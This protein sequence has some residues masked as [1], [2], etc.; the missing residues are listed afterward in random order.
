MQKQDWTP[1]C[2]QAVK[3]YNE[4]NESKT[5]KPLNVYDY[6]NWLNESDPSVLAYLPKRS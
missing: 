3:K 1:A 4:Q 5:G 2:S 6:L